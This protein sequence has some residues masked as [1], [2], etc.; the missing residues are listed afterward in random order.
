MEMLIREITEYRNN[1]RIK[2]RIVISIG[3]GKRKEMS[4]LGIGPINLNRFSKPV[5][6]SGANLGN[7]HFDLSYS[8]D[9]GAYFRFD[10]KDGLET[11]KEDEWRVKGSKIVKVFQ[12]SEMKRRPRNETLDTIA[13]HTSAY[14]STNEV[15]EWMSQCAEI[16]VEA[17][18]LR[19]RFDPHRWK[20]LCYGS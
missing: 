1:T 18:R 7:I 2:P 6:P 9:G 13:K 17:R 8:L 15:Q 4:G 19:A 16:L 5:R 20:K 14:I 12:R 10:V 11:I 3:S